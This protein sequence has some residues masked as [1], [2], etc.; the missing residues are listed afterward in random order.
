MMTHIIYVGLLVVFAC[1]IV[2]CLSE[3][4]RLRR[5]NLQACANETL[6]REKAGRLQEELNSL[7]YRKKSQ[8]DHRVMILEDKIT[9]LNGQIELQ[10]MRHKTEMQKADSEL[11]TK[12]MLITT[13]KQQIDRLSGWEEINKTTKK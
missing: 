11:R 6:A 7:K 3:M 5:E 9:E 10:E 4:D 2:H 8:S 1:V 12:E 13:F